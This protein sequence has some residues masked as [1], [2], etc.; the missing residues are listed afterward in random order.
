MLLWET[1][2]LTSESAYKRGPWDGGTVMNNQIR[3]VQV[4]TLA[5]FG[6]A[7]LRILL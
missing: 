4:A 3:S 7:S 2:V 1:I 5:G 6:E